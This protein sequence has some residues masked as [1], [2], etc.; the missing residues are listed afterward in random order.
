MDTVKWSKNKF[1]KI[2]DTLEPEL[3]KLGFMRSN[4]QFI[5]VSAGLNEQNI[6]KAAQADWYHGKTLIDALDHSATIKDDF[7]KDTTNLNTN[8]KIEVFGIQQEKGNIIV[9]TKVKQGILKTGQT[10]TILPSNMP[11]QA[12]ELY[13]GQGKSVNQITADELASFKINIAHESN[14]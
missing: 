5:P 14:I 4:V 12:L 11:A 8:L 1:D 7:K 3:T 10:L 13:D 9:N 2:K 6:S